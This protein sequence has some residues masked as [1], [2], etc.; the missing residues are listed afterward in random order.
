MVVTLDEGQRRRPIGS[1][2]CRLPKWREKLKLRA[3]IRIRWH[4]VNRQT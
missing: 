2:R 1:I 3:A 4:V